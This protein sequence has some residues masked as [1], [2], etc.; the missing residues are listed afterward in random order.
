MGEAKYLSTGTKSLLICLCIFLGHFLFLGYFLS[1]SLIYKNFSYIKNINLFVFIY[2]VVMLPDFICSSI[3]ANVSFFLHS[4]ILH[5]RSNAFM[6][7][8]QPLS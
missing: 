1:F 5:S 2:M 8:Q 3:K 6:F 4:L 7:V